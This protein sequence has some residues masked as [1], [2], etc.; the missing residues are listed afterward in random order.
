MMQ[1]HVHGN[2]IRFFVPTTISTL[3]LYS[4]TNALVS[5]VY[6]TLRHKTRKEQVPP[7]QRGQPS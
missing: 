1:Y 3:Y 4:M 6:V 2:I 7:N 5:I